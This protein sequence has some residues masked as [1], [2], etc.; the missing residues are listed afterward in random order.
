MATL[1]EAGECRI[2]VDPGATLVENRYNMPP[3]REEHQALEAAKSSIIGALCQ[4][5]AVVV[6]HYHDDHMNLLPYVLSST[7]IYLKRPVT[8]AEHR[9]AGE[10]FPRLQHTGRSFT[11]ADNTSV[12]LRDVSLSFSAPL[13]HGKS[14]AKLGSVMATAI[15]S[16]EGC[17]VHASDVQGPMSANAL[18]WLLQQRP[19]YLYLSGAPTYKLYTQAPQAAD[20]FTVQDLRTAKA[21]LLT[22]MKYSGCE[23]ILDHYATRDRNFRR[24]YSDVLAR[25][26]VYTAAEFLGVPERPLEAR[27][28]DGNTAELDTLIPRNPEAIAVGSGHTTKVM[29]FAETFINEREAALAGTPAR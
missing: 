18:A 20:T 3:S 14:G 29:D 12:G 15:R 4:A 9:I 5:D 1:V 25:G 28:Q 11:L 27:R 16:R 10:L 21:N 8:P 19:D 22:L 2:L 7:A 24:Q 23:V 13:S 26:N 6:T 17:F